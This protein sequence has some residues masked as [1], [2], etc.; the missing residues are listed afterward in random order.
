MNTRKTIIFGIF[1]ALIAGI[2][3]WFFALMN[4]QEQENI[5]EE[6]KNLFPFGELNPRN[7]NSNN[8]NS[9]IQEQEIDKDSKKEDN[10][11]T[12]PE[13]ILAPR[14]RKVFNKEVS[15]FVGLSKNQEKVIQDIQINAQGE[16]EYT[17]KTI[18]LEKD[19]VRLVQSS[20]GTIFDADINPYEITSEILV[21][22][23]IPN[24]ERSFFSKKD[25]MEVIHQYWDNNE[26]QIESY[27][28]SIS[29]IEI[30]STQCKTD[31][32][33]SPQVGDEGEYVLNLHEFLNR[34]PQTRVSVS[35]ANSPGNETF[36]TTELTITAIKNFQSLHNLKIDGKIGPSTK[37]LML[38][39]CT[40]QEQKIAQDKY[41]KLERKYESRGKF[42]N[43]NIL[44]IST[45]PE[46]P[47]FF[48][49]EENADIGVLGY[50]Q[51]FKTKEK[52]QIFNSSFSEWLSS[53]KSNNSI[54]I[55]TKAHSEVA[56]YSYEM[57]PINGD[58]HKRIGDLKGLTILPGPDNK[59]VLISYVEEEDLKLAIYN[60]ETNRKS[61][62][63]LKT[64]PEKC[65]WTKNARNI[66]CAVPKN[67]EN[68]S[69]PEDWYQGRFF[70]QDELW[71]IDAIS[72]E[73]F[74]INDFSNSL[75][76][77][78][79]VDKIN[80][81]NNENYLYFTNKENKHLWSYRLLDV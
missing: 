70:N 51:N 53:W 57:N 74:L 2:L 15:G 3:V 52:S 9:S 39:I 81:S 63:N 22:N 67:S 54:E 68:N 7:P 11:A 75:N 58:Y 55:T 12:E 79:D 38:D 27:L 8:Q 30:E 10:T 37:K 14:L 61:N 23:F 65:T 25:G 46:N 20:N 50:I 1:F 49:L 33:Q 31:F 78:I 42:L 44:D 72:K 60:K 56:G 18:N 48:Y 40:E 36:L 41:D 13:K 80:F 73:I 4:K 59:R 76:E 17:D 64:L 16:T 77:N 21:E 26:K 71:R 45:H 34:T 35:G 19:F 47:V 32:S 24:I 62:I 28:A 6:T 69:Y 29:K 43:Q 66:Y 5:I